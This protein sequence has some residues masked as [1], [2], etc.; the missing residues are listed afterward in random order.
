MPTKTG[1]VDITF[2]VLA[3]LSPVL[4]VKKKTATQ[5]KEITKKQ[6]IIK[7]PTSNKQ[8][9]PKQTNQPK[10]QTNPQNKTPTETK[11]YSLMSNSGWNRK[12]AIRHPAKEKGVFFFY[13]SLKI[14][15]LL[16]NIVMCFYQ[17]QDPPQRGKVS[18]YDYQALYQFTPRKLQ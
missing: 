15:N 8:K 13:M 7:T 3:F 16:H 12:R 11:I 6:R 18:D 14:Q 10:T 5:N 1:H 4:L 17:I 2:I 9:K